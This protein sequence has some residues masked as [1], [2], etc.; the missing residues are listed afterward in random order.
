M[1]ILLMKTINFELSKSMKRLDFRKTTL[2]FLSLMTTMDNEIS[3]LWKNKRSFQKLGEE[4]RTLTKVIITQIPLKLTT[5]S[6]MMR[7]NMR[8]LWF[9]CSILLQIHSKL[10]TLKMLKNS[11]S[12][13]GSIKPSFIK[14][15]K[16]TLI[17]CLTL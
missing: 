15:S 4:M 11:V 3:K 16:K 17:E 8:S 12:L 10:E 7:R 9:I 13:V 6:D 14:S 2:K 1:L 5:K